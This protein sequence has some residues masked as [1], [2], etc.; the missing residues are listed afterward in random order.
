MINAIANRGKENGLDIR[1]ISYSGTP[2]ILSPLAHENLV[3]IT[4]WFYC[5]TYT[6]SLSGIFLVKA[7]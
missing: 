1:L 6:V 3:V 2:L 5:S 7:S 4:G